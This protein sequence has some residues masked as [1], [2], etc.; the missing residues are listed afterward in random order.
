MVYDKETLE[1]RPQFSFT[2]TEL[3]HI[4][5]AAKADE[6]VSPKT[7]EKLKALWHFGRTK[8]AY[9]QDQRKA[10]TTLTAS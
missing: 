10:A 2:H 9:A 7:L 8:S 4:Y 5:E 6:D 3:A 1:S